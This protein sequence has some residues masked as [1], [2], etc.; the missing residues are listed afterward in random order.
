MRKKPSELD[1]EEYIRQVEPAKREKS[2]AWSTAIGLQQVD[3]LTPS[4]YLLEVAK[5]NIEGKISLNKAQKLID[6]YYESKTERADD[7]DDTEEA[8]KVSARIAQILSEKSFN[9]SPSFL[10]AIHKR[11]FEGVFKHAGEIRKYDI[12]KK[13]WVLNGDSVMYGASFELRMALDYDFERER[14]FSY[15]NIS[16]DEIVRH[17]AFFVSRLWQIHA[18]GEGNTRTTAVFTIKYLRS[19]GFKVGNDIFAKNSWYFRNA[20][21]RAN[22][23]NVRKGIQQEPEYLEKFFRNLLMGEHNELKNRYL[24]VDYKKVK[25]KAVIEK[26]KPN[27]A[28]KRSKNVPV[29]VPINVLINVPIKDR[30]KK[31]IAALSKDA[32]ASAQKLAEKFGVTEKTIRRDLQLLKQQNIIT[33]VGANKNG[34]WKVN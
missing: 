7:K 6:S 15:S 17:L 20:L 8:D 19:M 14:E 2:Y 29:N 10:I 21:V 34:Y 30:Q 31:I 23:K 22:Y 32:H 12:S 24:H 13:E 18:F 27:V 3:G 16:M 33:R 4:D 9:F 28:K 26:S 5:K 11:L 1:F 25:G